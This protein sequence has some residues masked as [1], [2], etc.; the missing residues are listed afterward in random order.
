[1][2]RR[3]DEQC[4]RNRVPVMASCNAGGSRERSREGAHQRRAPLAARPVVDAREI[5]PRRAVE[6]V[7]IDVALRLSPT[8]ER[9][10][11]RVES[12]PNHVVRI[13]V[14]VTACGVD[15][16]LTQHGSWQTCT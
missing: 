4:D 8:K 12:P 11:V 16:N 6:P 1:M 15:E 9:V 13:G 5:E 2:E 14:E 3:C 10:L 7:G